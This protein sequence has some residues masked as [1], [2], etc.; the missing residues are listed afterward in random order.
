MLIPMKNYYKIL[1]VAP[2][3]DARA[4]KAAYRRLALTCHPDVARTADTRA[5]FAEIQEAA[6][7]LLDPERRQIY[8][9]TVR[10]RAARPRPTRRRPEPDVPDV[11]G[12]V[13][14]ALGIR[15]SATVAAGRPRRRRPAR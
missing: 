15:I 5:R 9:D 14:D 13:I 4:I 6:T 8:D 1:G 2:E 3:A 12:V 7:V 11:A 10:S